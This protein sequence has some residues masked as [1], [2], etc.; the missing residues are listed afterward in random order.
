MKGRDD[1]IQGMRGASP[2]RPAEVR[3]L[4]RRRLQTLVEADIAAALSLHASDY[5]LIPPNGQPISRD[6]YLGMIGRREFVYDVFEPASDIAVRAYG[7]VVAVRYRA[8]IEAHWNGGNDRGLFW[9][10]DIYERRDGRWQ[11]VWS[12]ATRIAER[13]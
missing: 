9:H 13:T 6:E 2:P 5:Q 10:T 3:S 7:V 12:Q 8:R 11:A 4:E 1:D